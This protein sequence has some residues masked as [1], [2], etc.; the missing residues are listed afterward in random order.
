M[1]ESNIPNVMLNS[2]YQMPQIG[3]G[4]WLAKG[5]DAVGAVKSA[6]KCGYRHIDCAFI[7]GNQ[8]EIGS[9]LK[10]VFQAGTVEVKNIIFRKKN[11][12]KPFL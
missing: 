11:K 4:T 3:L 1:V 10:D 8:K 9:A 2:G 12:T 5:D 6:I 7:Y